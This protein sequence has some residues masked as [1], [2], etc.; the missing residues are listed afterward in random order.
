MTQLAVQPYR[1]C[2]GLTIVEVLAALSIF[3]IVGTGLAANS[4]GTIQSNWTSRS[5]S[6]ASTLAGDK[7]EQIRSMDPTTNPA[8]LT[9]GVEHVDANNPM[10][11]LGQPGGVYNRTWTVTPNTP[12]LGL[13]MISVQVSW[14]Q[15]GTERSVQMVGYLCRTQSCT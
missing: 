14:T 4:I 15:G 1:A 9:T 10:N 6:V 8:D 2:D 5:I 3:A 7:L 11:S 13:S 12:T